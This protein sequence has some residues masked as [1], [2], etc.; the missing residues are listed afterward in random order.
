MID[1]DTP[2]I[3]RQFL[4]Y[5]ETIKGQSP[6]NNDEKHLDLPMFQRFIFHIRS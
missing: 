5:H 6:K 4:A 2:E 1:P 3:L